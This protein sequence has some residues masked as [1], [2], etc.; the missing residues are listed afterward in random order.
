MEFNL[1]MAKLF[2]FVYGAGALSGAMFT[3]LWY[4][5]LIWGH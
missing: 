5:K 1:G 4:N 2:L 3:I